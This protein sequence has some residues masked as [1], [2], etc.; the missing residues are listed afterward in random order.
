MLIVVP[1][2]V[3]MYPLSAAATSIKRLRSVGRGF[4]GERFWLA[5]AASIVW[6]GASPV[7]PGEQTVDAQGITP[8]AA[9]AADALSYHYATKPIEQIK[10]GDYVLA[11]NPAT[12]TIEKKRV[13]ATFIRT[14]D[15]IRVLDFQS[16]NGD[17]QR[18]ETTDEHPYYLPQLDTFVNAADLRTGDQVTG[19]NGERQRLIASTRRDEPDGVTVYNFSVEDHHVYFVHT[20]SPVLVHNANKKKYGGRKECL[21]SG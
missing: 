3:R 7:P 13:E 10:E 21:M 2:A 5:P 11:R 12:G 19:L 18:H 14:C 4:I 17:I 1:P 15:H 9:A 16:P 8:V 20:A 6:T